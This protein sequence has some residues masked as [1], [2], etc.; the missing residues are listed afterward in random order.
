MKIY[1]HLGDVFGRY[2]HLGREREEEPVTCH[3]LSL[4]SRE[5]YSIHIL[6]INNQHCLPSRWRN[7][8]IGVEGT[9][10]TSI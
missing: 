8:R 7:G 2:G 4:Q 10:F 3:Y 9:I 1:G 6:T 5:Q